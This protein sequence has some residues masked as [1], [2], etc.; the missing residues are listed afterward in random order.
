M[1]ARLINRVCYRYGDHCLS[2]VT[3]DVVLLK[4]LAGEP[5]V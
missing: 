1:L 3:T 5:Y 2:R 4:G